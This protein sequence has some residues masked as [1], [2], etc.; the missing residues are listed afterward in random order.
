M[1]IQGNFSDLYGTTMLPLIKGIIGKYYRDRPVQFTRVFNV[2]SSTRSAEQFTDFSG[3]GRFSQIPEGS[4]VRRDQP[5]QGFNVSFVPVRYGLAIP[6]SYEMVAND[7]FGIIARMHRDLAWSCRETREIQAATTFNNGF[8]S[9]YLGPDGVSLFNASHPLYKVGGVQS[10]LGTAADLDMLPYQQALTAL[11]L[12]KR[13]S[14][15]F[16]HTVPANLI[17]HPNNRFVA[18]V[19]TKSTDDPTTADRSTNPLRGA[20]DGV[21]TMFVWRYLTNTN[22]W[23]LTAQPDQ[24]GLVWFDREQPRTK[25][26]TDDETEVGVTAMRYWKSHGWNDYIGTYGNAG[27]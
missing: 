7:K 9:S 22:A 14:G 2:E 16:V 19:L 4:P 13:P 10:N 6:T 21:P 25:S 27:V 20:E 3:V 17:V 5:V 8:S 11:E 18:H 24:T 26:W 1:L 23:F 12:M 15:E